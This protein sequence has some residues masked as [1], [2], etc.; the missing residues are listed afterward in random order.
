[1]EDHLIIS[2]FFSRDERAIRET[3]KKYGGYLYTVAH[4]I[5]SSPQDA[6]ES[7][8]STYHAAWNAIPPQRPQ[9]L[10][11]FLAKITR[12]ISLNTWR[13]NHAEKRGGGEVQ[14]ALDELSE[15]LPGHESVE[16]EAEY[17]HLVES[18]NR[19][20]AALSADDRRIFV[21]RYFH[22]CPVSDIAVR[23]RFS[24]SKVKTSLH[25]TRE[26]LRAH[27]IKEGYQP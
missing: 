2:L 13:R 22:L 4:R 10:S 14:L 5:L 20:L 27:L 24:E 3:A 21:L 16:K 26:K 25:R 8:S 6:E 18:L 15:C 7:V 23:C 1:M 11:S 19:F 12:S 9:R 17:A